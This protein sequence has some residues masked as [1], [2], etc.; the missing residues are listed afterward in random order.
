MSFL[1]VSTFIPIVVICL[2]AGLAVKA[3]K[4]KNKWIPIIVGLL[5]GIIGAYSFYM[6]PD[7]PA[8]NVLAGI[9]VGIISGLASTGMH[10]AVK[11]LT[12]NKN[13]EER[14]DK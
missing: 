2:L 3:S 12:K 9:A 13:I 5:G 10:E 1:G 8:D 6:I 7:F 4:I 11:Q 14:C